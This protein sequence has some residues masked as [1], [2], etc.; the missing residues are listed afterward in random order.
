[1]RRLFWVGVGVAVTVVVYRRGRKVVQQYLPA[2]VAE[3]AGQ[4]AQDAGERASGFVADF[5]ETFGE[6][7][8]RR[9]AELTAALLAE[10]QPDPETTRAQRAAGGHRATGARRAFPAGGP[11]AGVDDIDDDEAELG[12]SF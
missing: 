7:R 12:Y 5:R 11:A 9:E 1:M 6:A 3:R 10:G 4:A 2:S 8:A